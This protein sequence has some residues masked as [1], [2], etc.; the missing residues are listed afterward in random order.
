MRKARPAS[1]KL[2]TGRR[3]PRKPATRKPGARRPSALKNPAPAAPKARRKHASPSRKGRKPANSRTRP[4]RRNSEATAAGMY[5]QFHQM[6]P[7]KIREVVIADEYPAELA[8]LG[9]LTM[10]GIVIAGDSDP[11]PFEAVGNI[12]VMCTAD[13]GQ[14]YFIG[15]DQ[16]TDLDALGLDY[17]LPKDHVY[18]GE[19]ELI[20]YTT[21]KGFHDFELT[22]Y[23]HE[24]GEDGGEPPQVHYD[25]INRRLYLTGGTYQVRR[26][27]IVN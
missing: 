23:H 3:A 27:G 24:L 18:I 22:D 16:S 21:R 6:P 25:T 13:G 7:K 4:R 10:L 11:T 1:K 2:S 8:D 19:A 17:Q 20:V 5:E 9:R 15:G 14:L 12:R 26:E